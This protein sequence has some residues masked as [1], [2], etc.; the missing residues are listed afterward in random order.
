M[1]TARAV[2]LVISNTL[3]VYVTYLLTYCSVY[4]LDVC[5]V[6]CVKCQ[7]DV[8]QLST[9]QHAIARQCTA[10]VC[11]PSGWLQSTTFFVS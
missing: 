7:C 11:N 5:L 1:Y 9:N 4:G 8:F 10:A 3:I 2:T 6:F